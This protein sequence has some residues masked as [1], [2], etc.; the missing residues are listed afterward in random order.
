MAATTNAIKM[1]TAGIVT[2]DGAGA[3]SATNYTDTNFTPDLKFGSNSVG[4]TYTTQV[5]YYTRIGNVVFISVNIVLSSK[6]SS[7]GFANFNGLPF[8]SSATVALYPLNAYYMNMASFPSGTT[9]PTARITASDTKFT[10]WGYLGGTTGTVAQ[11][12]DSHFTN[13]STIF[14]D[15]FYRV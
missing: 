3:F 5:G 6:G 12:G 2:Y 4:L 10:I 8:T 7:T 13:T 15:G 11:M 1:T 14:V 9:D